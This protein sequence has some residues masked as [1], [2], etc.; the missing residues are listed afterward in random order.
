MYYRKN[1]R[2]ILISPG[3]GKFVLMNITRVQAP[4][5]TVHE[6]H[7]ILSNLFFRWT[8]R[9]WYIIADCSWIGPNHPN[10]WSLY[11]SAVHRGGIWRWHL[12]LYQLTS[13]FKTW[14]FL[15]Q[16]FMYMNMQERLSVLLLEWCM[17]KAL[18]FITMR[19]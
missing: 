7:K 17:E 10:F 12:S 2:G 13:L 14:S 3:P 15:S 9:F 19:N 16:T 8:A 1:P 4:E 18:Q 5:Y 6:Y 11:G